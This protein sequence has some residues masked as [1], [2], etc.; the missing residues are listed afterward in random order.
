MNQEHDTLSSLESEDTVPL[1][2]G[3]ELRQAREQG[4]QTV[5][6]VASVLFVRPQMISALEAE[7]LTVFSAPVYAIGLLR[8]YARLLDIPLD[9]LLAALEAMEVGHEPQLTSISKAV[10]PASVGG[11]S[12]A[13]GL[14][15]VAAIVALGIGVVFFQGGEGDSQ[16]PSDMV[17]EDTETRSSTN[18]VDDAASDIPDTP[19]PDSSIVER[20]NIGADV[21]EGDAS[22]ATQA[23]EAVTETAPVEDPRATDV[24][25][26]LIF[27]TDS[28]AEVHDAAGRRLLTRIGRAGQK[29]SLMGQPPFDVRLGY[30]PGVRIEYNGQPYVWEQSKR[31][32]VAH[33]QVGAAAKP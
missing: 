21:P 32:R 26:L 17:A 18:L 10:H 4:G 1:S 31:S 30:A 27:D 2:F 28:W 22:A 29:L 12:I 11:R 6:E 33:L 9:P 7:D 25:L 14:I 15:A 16:D 3:A 5:D 19:L 24:S 13:M 8:S 23:D 20:A